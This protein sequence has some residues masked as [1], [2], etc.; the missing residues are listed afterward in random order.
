MPVIDVIRQKTSDLPFRWEPPVLCYSEG[1]ETGES[2]GGAGGGRG[3]GWEEAAG[4]RTEAG[5]WWRAAT[6]LSSL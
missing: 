6:S 4:G 1:R 2:A 5:R 3:R